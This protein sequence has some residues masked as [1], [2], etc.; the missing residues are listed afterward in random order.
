MSPTLDTALTLLHRSI[1]SAISNP[2]L[3]LEKR[4]KKKKTKVK[5]GG[6]IF[7]ENWQL[8]LVIIAGIIAA[9][10]IGCLI[11]YLWKKQKA[12]K[13]LA[14][15]GDQ[16]N[17]DP[18]WNGPGTRGSFDGVNMGEAGKYEDARRYG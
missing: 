7:G 11:W 13:A 16:E 18:Y 2:S 14:F 4:K 8:A 3:S 6:A 9:I 10:L 17:L 5:G 12:K 15:K 1:D